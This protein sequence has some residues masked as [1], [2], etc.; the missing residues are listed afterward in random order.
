MAP[1]IGRDAELTINNVLVGYAKNFSVEA[2]ADVNKD[3]SM[4]ARDPAVLEAGNNSYRFTCSKM[5][6][7]NA[8]QALLTAGTKFSVKFAPAGGSTVPYVTLNNCVIT[9]WRLSAGMDG[10]VLC[11][12]AGEAASLTPTNT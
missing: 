8:Y 7:D 11:D 4:D 5:F 1:L 10:A 2:S 9:S 6:V 12:V 3:Y